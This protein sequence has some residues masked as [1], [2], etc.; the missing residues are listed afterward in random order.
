MSLVNDEESGTD[1]QMADNMIKCLHILD[2]TPGEITIIHNNLGGDWYHCLAIYDAIRLCE[3]N[4]IIKI[5]GYG[6]SSGSVILQAADTR[7]VAPNARIMIHYG[8]G[9]GY[10]HSIDAVKWGEE[11]IKQ[12]KVLEDIYLE[13]IKKKHPRFTRRKIKEMLLNDTILTAQETV[14]LGLADDIL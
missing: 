3:N 13:Q 8:T 2:Q 6:M 9:G 1:F 5:F 4:T 14:D 10:G 12:L 11:H 7:L